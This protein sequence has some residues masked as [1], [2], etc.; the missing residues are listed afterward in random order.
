MKINEWILKNEKLAQAMKAY[1][2]EI[3]RLER[4]KKLVAEKPF[5]DSVINRSL[6]YN[7]ERKISKAKDI[8]R[9]WDDSYQERE[10]KAADRDEI[11]RAYILEIKE[12]CQH[13]EDVFMRTK[14]ESL[15]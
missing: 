11:A 6:L 15:W 3:D 4:F 14:I 12:N 5:P 9:V 13:I 1:S 10:D 7:L 2:D 8:F